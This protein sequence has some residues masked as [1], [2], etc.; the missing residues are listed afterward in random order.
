M[1]ARAALARAIPCRSSSRDLTPCADMQTPPSISIAV[2]RAMR[3]NGEVAPTTDFPAAAPFL[4]TPTS[5]G[6]CKP[7]MPTGLEH[8]P[9]RREGGDN[10]CGRAEALTLPGSSRTNADDCLPPASLGRV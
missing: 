4:P 9:G 6:R 5:L 2:L 1:P 8:D 3:G 7:S 10:P